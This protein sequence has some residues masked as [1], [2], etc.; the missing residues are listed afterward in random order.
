MLQIDRQRAPPRNTAQPNQA[1]C[2]PSKPPKAIPESHIT[3]LTKH[4]S[5]RAFTKDNSDSLCDKQAQEQTD[6][7]PKN[8]FSENETQSKRRFPG[9]SANQPMTELTQLPNRQTWKI[10]PTPTHPEDWKT[11]PTTN[12]HSAYRKTHW[13]A[14]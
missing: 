6:K 9:E 13:E 3:A 1:S 5:E 8:G 7:S 11:D 2:A 4:G 12:T 10:N 14:I